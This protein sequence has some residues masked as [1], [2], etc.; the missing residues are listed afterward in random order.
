MFS[1]K[2]LKFYKR[3]KYKTAIHLWYLREAPILSLLVFILNHRLYLWPGY[4]IL[5]NK[6]LY[7]VLLKNKQTKYLA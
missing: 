2:V 3:P 6:P 7:I 4:V 1:M 5:D